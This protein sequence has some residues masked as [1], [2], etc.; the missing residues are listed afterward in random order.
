ME[1]ALTRLLSR[2]Q[3]RIFHSTINTINGKPTKIH[4]SNRLKLC[5]SD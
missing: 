5:A 1:K 2:T 3:A 4:Q